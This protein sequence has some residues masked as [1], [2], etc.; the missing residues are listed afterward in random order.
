MRQQ[1]GQVSV[2][3]VLFVLI[4][5]LIAIVLVDL[6]HLEEARYWGY[7]VAQQ[8][9]MAGVSR[10][11]DWT[12]TAVTP[13]PHWTPPPP[14]E[15]FPPPAMSLDV[16]DATQNA[17]EEI[18]RE[19]N[20]RSIVGYHYEIHVLPNPGGG[21]ISDFPP[22]DVRMAGHLEDDWIT[23]NPAV[24]VYL[25]FPVN[26]FLMSFIG[27]PTITLHVFSAAEVKEPGCP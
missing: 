6:Y 13:D 5:L 26:T 3:T 10:G 21:G 1:K 12:I 24:G 14:G 15:C 8:A 17:I 27:K 18:T 20:D 19:M 16:T 4:F 2:L 7:Q 11:R 9:A 22:I 25:E 23:T